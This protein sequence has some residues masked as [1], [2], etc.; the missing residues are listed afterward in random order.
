MTKPKAAAKDTAIVFLTS[1][2]DSFLSSAADSF[3]SSANRITPGSEET[4]R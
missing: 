2:A 4:R 1:L 3:F